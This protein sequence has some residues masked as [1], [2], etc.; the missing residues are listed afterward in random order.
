MRNSNSIEKEDSVLVQKCMRFERSFHEEV[1][2]ESEQTGEDYSKI[3][4]RKLAERRILKEENEKLKEDNKFLEE[5]MSLSSSD[6]ETINKALYPDCEDA[7]LI[8][9]EPSKREC[10]RKEKDRYGHLPKSNG[11]FV[12]DNPRKCVRCQQKERTYSP[13]QR[14]ITKSAQYNGG[15]PQTLHE[16]IRTTSSRLRMEWIQKYCVRQFSH[17]NATN[18]S[19]CHQQCRLGCKNE[20]QSCMDL[21]NRVLN[22]ETIED[23]VNSPR[24]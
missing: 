8:K 16:E 22:G 6:K 17:H 1:L 5:A 14:T 10:G 2:K 11:I 15:S 13:L 24:Y 20:Y 21:Y 23:I 18:D 4:R 9:G 12:V 7:Y 3:V 19:Y